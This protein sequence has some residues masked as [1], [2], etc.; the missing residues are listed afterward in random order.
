[1]L[2]QFIGGILGAIVYI[3]TVELHHPVV[4]EYE[5]EMQ[6]LKVSAE[7]EQ[8][9]LLKSTNIEVSSNVE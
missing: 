6:A 4:E 2:G 8:T 5:V 7:D 9:S 1:M 3:L